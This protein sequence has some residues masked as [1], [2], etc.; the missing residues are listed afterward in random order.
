MAV[1][2]KKGDHG[3]AVAEL[4]RTLNS[5]G[6]KLDVDGWFGD[7]TEAAVATVQRRAGL[8]VDG[9]VGV[10][11]Q[12]ALRGQQDTRRMCEADLVA[13]ADRLGVPLACVKAVNAVESRGSG[14]LDDGRPAILLERHIAYRQGKEAGMPVD[15]M[16]SRYSNLINPKRGGYAGGSA[17]WARFDNLRSITSQQ[18]AVEACSWGMFQVMGYHWAALGYADAEDFQRAMMASEANQLD[19]FVR[20]VL[21]DPALSK[22]LKAKKWAEFARL[23]N[24]PAYKENLYDAKLAAAYAA[25]ER[26]AA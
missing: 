1:T 3:S 9:I 13:A 23:Y 8:V 20:Y 19:A 6:A 7:A 11:T 24:G 10:K 17:E 14:F 15:V 26:L 5:H 4:Q 16:A 22:A 25:A 21:L 18:I 12:E 2:I